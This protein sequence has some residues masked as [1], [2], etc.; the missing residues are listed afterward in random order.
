M[1]RVF[2]VQG[3][4][5]V[6][7]EAL[8]ARGWVEQRILRPNQHAHWHHSYDSSASSNDAGDSNSDD[9]ELDKSLT[10]SEIIFLLY[11]EY[12]FI[13]P[14]INIAPSSQTTQMMSK[15]SRIQMNCM[16]SW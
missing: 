12:V 16:I 3:P 15:K 13:S 9:G 4:Y 14:L 8:R 2:S 6:I 10:V 1:R 5:S 7:R 11:S